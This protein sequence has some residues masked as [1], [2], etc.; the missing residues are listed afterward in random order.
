MTEFLIHI[1]MHACTRT[2]V[3]SAI[4]IKCCGHLCIKMAH[5]NVDGNHYDSKLCYLC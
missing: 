3:Y 1:K 4:L 2:T 5:V